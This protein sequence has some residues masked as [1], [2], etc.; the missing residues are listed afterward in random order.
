[1]KDKGERAGVAWPGR[2]PLDIAITVPSSHDTS[3]VPRECFYFIYFKIKRKNGCN[4]KYDK[5]SLVIVIFISR[6]L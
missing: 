4:N 3:R 6:Q 2:C 5:S 1:M